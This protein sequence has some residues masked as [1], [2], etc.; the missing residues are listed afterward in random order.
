MSE[1]LKPA[2]V[3]WR[4]GSTPRCPEEGHEDAGEWS[5]IEGHWSNRDDIA[6]RFGLP[7]ALP[8]AALLLECWRREGEKLLGVMRGDFALLIYREGELIAAR[9][10]LGGRPM[11]LTERHD[12]VALDQDAR[13]LAQLSGRA[14]VDYERLSAFVM[15]LPEEGSH[16]FYR[17]VARIEQGGICRVRMGH[18]SGFEKWFARGQ[19]TEPGNWQDAVGH[20]AALLDQAVRRTLGKSRAPTLML[21]SG[22]DSNLILSRAARHAPSLS[23][24]CAAPSLSSSDARQPE[25]DESD[26]ACRSARAFRVPCDIVR[27]EPGWIE[28]VPDELQIYGRPYYNPSNARWLG[29]VR[30]AAAAKGSDLLLHGLLGN[31]T[32]SRTRAGGLSA[33]IAARRWS[34]VR[35]E[36]GRTWRASPRSWWR[37]VRSATLDRLPHPVIR[38]AGPRSGSQLAQDYFLHADHEAVG[39]ALAREIASGVLPH[40][41][42]HR[43]SEPGEQWRRL[44][45]FMDPGPLHYGL[46]RT[47]GFDLRDPFADLDLVEACVAIPAWMFADAGIDRALARELLDENIPGSIRE[48]VVRA[49]QGAD[50][51]RAEAAQRGTSL[52]LLDWAHHHSSVAD[53]FDL[54]ALRE[55]VKNGPPSRAG[56]RAGHLSYRSRCGNALAA[57]AFARWV[58]DS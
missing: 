26:L 12:G 27:T 21:S 44:I 57:L 47:F 53:V 4:W 6:A 20:V 46:R 33:A 1:L 42:D 8:T 32:I 5:W 36:V 7:A 35:S 22:L 15:V 34:A 14:E 58:E 2:L 55:M 40:R 48:G 29:A 23:A 17:G 13:V 52:D 51:A 56:D 45:N 38:A 50:W 16:S 54:P 24:I 3:S 11:F 25:Y 10:A 37:E 19:M 28:Q 30:N 39:R 9:D 41:E 49:S 31:F 18:S 43:I